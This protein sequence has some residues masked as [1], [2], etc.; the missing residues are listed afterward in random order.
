MTGM[1]SVAVEWSL[2]ST[3]KLPLNN[4][5]FRWKLPLRLLKTLDSA[6]WK[7]QK[8]YSL[9]HEQSLK[10]CMKGEYEKWNIHKNICWI[11]TGNQTMR[12]LWQIN[13]CDGSVA[14]E[15]SNRKS[16]VLCAFMLVKIFFCLYYNSSFHI[17]KKYTNK[18][19]SNIL[20]FYCPRI[21]FIIL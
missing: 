4:N 13:L 19:L 14:T 17:L 6:S 8:K 20:A 2:A 1:C 9:N 7:Y 5:G 21:S 16:Q 10:T 11:A 3:L 18:F 15:A 12:A